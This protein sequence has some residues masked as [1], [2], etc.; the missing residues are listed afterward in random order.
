MMYA[1]V[2]GIMHDFPFI[3]SK[4]KREVLKI[5]GDPHTPHDFKETTANVCI[6]DF[7]ASLPLLASRHSN[8]NPLFSRWLPMFN[9]SHTFRGGP[10]HV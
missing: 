3:N 1:N 5:K 9:A 2:R 10:Q 7:V 4:I 6:C 8:K